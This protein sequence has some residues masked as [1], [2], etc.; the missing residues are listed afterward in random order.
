MT[1]LVKSILALLIVLCVLAAFYGLFLRAYILQWGADPQEVAAVLPGDR[2]APFIGST[3]AITINTPQLE[4]WKCLAQLGADRAG[5]Y[6]YTFLEELMGFHGR[7]TR[8]VLPEHLELQAGRVVPT[9][10]QGSDSGPGWEFRVL[11]VDPGNHAVLEG[12][13]T[14]AL[15]PLGPGQTR[16]I[17]RTNGWELPDIW[18]RAAFFLFMPMHYIMERKMMMGI[19]DT[20]EAGG[21]AQDASWSDIIWVGSAFLSLLG[22]VVMVFAGR[23]IHKL[24]WPI[25]FGILWLLVILYFEPAGLYGL[26]LLLLVIVAILCLPRRKRREPGRLRY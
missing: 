7:E 16:L 21:R 12:W 17:V 5:F 13:G 6:G 10:R 22:I 1:N 19:R 3:R 20:A 4:V 25:V 9:S 15:K 26:G 11:E 2:L 24:L 18:H 23:G 14:L 8:E